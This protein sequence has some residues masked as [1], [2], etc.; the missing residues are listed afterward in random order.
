MIGSAYG[1]VVKVLRVIGLREEEP[2]L[3]HQSEV[4]KYKRNGE[5]A[6]REQAECQQGERQQKRPAAGKPV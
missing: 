2:A 6:R 4:L 3:H 5:Q 1:L